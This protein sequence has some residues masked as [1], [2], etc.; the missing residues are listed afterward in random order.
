[1]YEP[2]TDVDVD[3]RLSRNT[4]SG[5]SAKQALIYSVYPESEGAAWLPDLILPSH[6]PSY[7]AGET[8]NVTNVCLFFLFKS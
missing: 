5:A 6:A 1:M 4:V 8:Q 2:L 7:I 3:M